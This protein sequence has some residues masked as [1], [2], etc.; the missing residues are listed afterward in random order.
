VSRRPPCLD[1]RVVVLFTS[2]GNEALHGF[3]A[4]LRRVA[5]L[6]VLL[7]TD[8]REDA[9]GFALCDDGWTVPARSDPAYLPTI[10][11][12]LR[13]HDVDLL[14]PL[15]TRDQDFFADPE[16]RGRLAAPVVA[17]S[18]ASLAAANTKVGLFEAVGDAG[19][20]L[21]H[22]RT[23][24]SVDAAAAA[25]RE[26]VAIHGAAVLKRDVGTGG[27]GMLFVGAPRADAAPVAGRTLLAVDDAVTGLRA[28]A[29]AFGLA[30][31]V[32]WLPGEEY[33]VDVLAEGGAVLAGVVRL[34]RA[35]IGGLATDS[36]TVH[37]PDVMAAAEQVVRRCGLDYVANV[38]FRRD[39]AGAPKLMEVNPR[40]PGTIGLTVEAGL[41]LPTAAAVLAL[42]E[43]PV[44]GEAEIGVRVLRHNGAVYRRTRTGPPPPAV[45]LQGLGERLAAALR[46][47]GEGTAAV[48][49]DLDGTLVRLRVSL[50]AIRSWKR[51]L[52]DRFAPLGWS[53]GWS[54]LLPSI[55]RALDHVAATRG[56]AESATLRVATYDDLDRWEAEAL[57]GVDP[58]P[59]AVG[60][61]AAQGGTCAT[62]IVTNNGPRALAAALPVLGPAAGS[63]SA[64]VH[65]GP[66]LPAKPSPAMFQVAVARLT[67]Q[68]GALGRIVVVGDSPGDAAAARALAAT[69]AVPVVFVATSAP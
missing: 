14:Y 11:R 65:R 47:P 35:S 24:R 41:D 19:D 55:E 25:L 17:A 58:I 34:R 69:V 33:S 7:G 43:R 10:E 1:R 8:M 59:E 40:I 5:P 42:G 62:A 4:A 46:G 36:E 38:Q 2:V 48:L 9:A 37:E 12:L 56:P 16:V 45:P 64:Y 6:W 44:L 54:P 3:A 23:V 39:A 49:W 22:H 57:E 52:E 28:E 30:Q 53:G 66:Q 61:L 50:D 68:T 21:P 18:A 20:L 32:A 26:F 13:D 31:V 51:T 60:L 27:A 67:P 29:G 15:S 63:V